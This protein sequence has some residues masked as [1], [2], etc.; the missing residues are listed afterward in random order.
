MNSNKRIKNNC[1][2]NIYHY[3]AAFT[4]KGILSPA[5]LFCT[6][7]LSCLFMI[8]HLTPATERRLIL[9]YYNIFLMS[10]KIV[11]LSASFSHLLSFLFLYTPHKCSKKHY[12]LIQIKNSLSIQI[13]Y[14]FSFSPYN[15]KRVAAFCA[16]T[17]FQLLLTKSMFKTSSEKMNAFLKHN[18]CVFSLFF[19]NPQRSHCIDDRNN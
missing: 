13:L 4:P 2:Q 12:F 17:L 10:R 6:T 11:L 15:W 7:L 18:L 5:D 1:V 14:L 3:C 9:L 8:P 16:A 19:W